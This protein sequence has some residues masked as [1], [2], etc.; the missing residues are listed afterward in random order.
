MKDFLGND[1]VQGDYFAYP[2]I[3][4]RSAN[5]AIFQFDKVDDKGKVKARPCTRAYG[6]DKLDYRIW[7][8]GFYD[9]EGV[10]QSGKY[11]D[12]TAEERIHADTLYERKR[13]TLQMFSERAILLPNFKEPTTE[14]GT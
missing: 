8:S 11:E 1:V 5:M 2:L 12:M 6:D 9:I 10:Y 7:R 3:I 13:S 14:D 4:G